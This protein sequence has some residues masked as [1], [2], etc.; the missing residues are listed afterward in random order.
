MA[1]TRLNNNSTSSVTTL[2]AVTSIPNLASLPSGLVA[3]TPAFYAVMSGANQTGMSPNTNT[4]VQFSSAVYDSNSAYDTSNY[5]FVV[6][7]GE[8]GKY[9]IGSNLNFGSTSQG[10]SS[11]ICVYKN[12]SQYQQFG[13]FFWSNYSTF[14]N[15][16]EGTQDYVV[17]A[18]V[19]IDLAENDYV[20]I[21][22]RRYD[23]SSI[24]F[25]GNIG[26]NFYG[27]KIIE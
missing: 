21:F 2:S 23:G 24:Y 22:G 16:I 11:F 19:I 3:N 14:P 12:G 10:R 6:P 1:I 25:R 13:Q 4:K 26:S 20:E 5:R 7:S 9:F 18:S 17:H 27:Y 8:G 15:I